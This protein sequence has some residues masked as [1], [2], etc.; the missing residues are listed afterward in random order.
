MKGI[1]VPDGWN[2]LARDIP[3][4]PPAP[5]PWYCRCHNQI[6][7]LHDG[8]ADVTHKGRTAFVP[9]GWDVICD[10]CGHRSTVPTFHKR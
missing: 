7:L 4:P 10:R 9:V 8:Y 2:S 5:R 3:P 1:R 6:G